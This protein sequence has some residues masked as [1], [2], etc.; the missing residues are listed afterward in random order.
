[1]SAGAKGRGRAKARAAATGLEQRQEQMRQGERGAWVSIAAYLFL[2]ALKLG[3]GYWANSRAL[4]ADGLNNTT[5]IVASVAVLVGLRI[6]RKPADED[7]R[8]GHWRAETIATTV[9][10]LIMAGVAFNVLWSAGVAMYRR[11]FVHPDIISMWTALFSAGVMML[12][13]GYNKRLG[14]RIQSAALLAAAA[15]NRSDALVSLGAFA[16]I[17]AGQFGLYWLDPVAALLVGLIILKTAYEIFTEA[18]HA[19]S[20]GYDVKHLQSIEAE[21]GAVQGVRSVVDLKGRRYG[22]NV[23]LDAVIGVAPDLSVEESHEITERVEQKLREREG[24]EN[25]HI[26]VEPEE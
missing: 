13:Y 10:A 4:F 9:A 6:A 7:H 25:V 21:I 11:D 1:M 20:D 3:V 18:A 14:Q 23:H 26:H 16:G 24:I 2:S 5:D 17:L 19:L 22:S 8:Y 15:D 12:V